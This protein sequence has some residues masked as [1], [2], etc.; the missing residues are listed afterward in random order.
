MKTEDSDNELSNIEQHQGQS[1]SQASPATKDM[2]R[3]R[4][5]NI[6][7]I[8]NKVAERWGLERT[9]LIIT[10][11]KDIKFARAVKRVV[12][13]GIPFEQVIARSNQSILRRLTWGRGRRGPPHLS[14]T[15]LNKILL[16]DPDAVDVTSEEAVR[17]GMVFDDLGFLSQLYIPPRP[18]TPHDKYAVPV[19][20]HGGVLPFTTPKIFQKST[21]TPKAHLADAR[22]RAKVNQT[23]SGAAPIRRLRAIQPL[24]P[25]VED[26]AIADV[27]TAQ[28]AGPPKAPGHMATQVATKSPTS[29]TDIVKDES[30]CQENSEE[31]HEYTSDLEAKQ[32]AIREFI[33]NWFEEEEGFWKDLEREVSVI[34]ESEKAG[35]LFIKLLQ[36]RLLDDSD[37]MT[38]EAIARANSM[39]GGPGGSSDALTVS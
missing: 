31:T 39:S 33:S 12:K 38:A 14:D 25:L 20:G 15:D 29:R 24:M 17:R 4:K 27:G 23:V 26:R 1:K 37:D 28:S 16:N 8:I 2:A 30:H 7:M 34:L 6:E 13:L 19:V 36:E 32:A 3:S 9:S 22:Q 35:K 11:D 5:D 10:P 21:M 18:T